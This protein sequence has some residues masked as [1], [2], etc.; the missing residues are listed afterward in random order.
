VNPAFFEQ[1]QSAVRD[2]INDYEYDFVA[3]VPEPSGTLICLGAMAGVLG[4][5]PGTWGRNRRQ[6]RRIRQNC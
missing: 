1:V 2:V 6:Q 5:T 3:F 4:M